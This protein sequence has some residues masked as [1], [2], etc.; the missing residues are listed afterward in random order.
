MD[1]VD[2]TQDP[3]KNDPTLRKRLKGH[4]SQAKEKLKNIQETLVKIYNFFKL[5]SAY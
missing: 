4:K 2:I 5:V 1:Q 3:A